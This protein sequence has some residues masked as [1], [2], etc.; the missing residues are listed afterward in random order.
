MYPIVTPK[1]MQELDRFGIEKIGLP[2]IVLMENAGRG[3]ISCIQQKYGSIENKHFGIICG[4]GNNGGD[5]FVVAR[6]LY[7][8]GAYVKVLILSSIDELKGDA[9]TNYKIIHEISKQK[10]AKR[11]IQIENI[12]S[13]RKLKS[14]KNFD[15]LVDAIF[16]TGFSGKTSGLIANVIDW[17]NSQKVPVI[18]IDIPSGVNGL[19]GMVTNNAVKSDLTITMGLKKIGLL[20]GNS[21]NYIND[22]KVV[23]I[24]LPKFLIRK[25][26]FKIFEVTKQDVRSKLPKRLKTVHKYSVGKVF[27]IAG[28]IGYTGAAAM[29]S[30]STLK[31]GA[32]A[33]VLGVPEKIYSILARKLTEVMVHPLDA[34]VEG[35]IA[36]TSFHK[37]RKFIDWANVI[38]IGPGISTN[39][40][41]EDVVRKVI[42]EFDKKFVIDADALTIISR[43]LKILLKRKSKNVILT[44]HIG[45]FSRL[46]DIPVSE[47]EKNK[48]EIARDFTK[49]FGVTLVLKGAPTITVTQD[50]FVYINSTGN[51][52]MATA[53][54]GDVLAGIISGLLVQGMNDIDAAL[55]G[56][57]IHGLAGDIAMKNLGVKSLMALDIQK[58]LPQAFKYIEKD[59]S[60]E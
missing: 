20:I 43:D 46:V 59:N 45:E 48:I 17:L 29:V 49:K 60:V 18:S 53:G 10:D 30:N 15:F 51:P 50:G 41:T 1:E 19:N 13:I 23:D 42:S 25:F 37:M 35:S 22:L 55:C 3:I 24:S 54:S 40:E 34:T 8:L 33:V 5:G 14:L 36:K 21:I 32:G 56:V 39:V 57:Y 12:N 38:V 44:P 4:K 6:H 11:F 28:S 2:G 26:K 47:I 58:Y 9:L 31:S 52:G 16:G 7:N 27:V